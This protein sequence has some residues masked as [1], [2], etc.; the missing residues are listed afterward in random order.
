[1]NERTVRMKCGLLAGSP[2]KCFLAGGVPSNTFDFR[3][4]FNW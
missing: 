4:T 2:A 1:M 3:G